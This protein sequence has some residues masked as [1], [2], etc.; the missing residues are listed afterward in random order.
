[1]TQVSLPPGERPRLIR[2]LLLKVHWIQQRGLPW[3]FRRLRNE[4]T[5]PTTAPTRAVRNLLAAL[6]GF[7]V[8]TAAALFRWL[9]SV[10]YDARR[11]L[12]FF[13]DLQVCP[14][15]YDIAT[16]MAG[17]ELER[18]RRG[19]A[20]IHVVIVPG[21]GDGLRLEVPEYDAIVSE[22]ARRWRLHN[23][24]VPV[25]GL[26]PSCGGFTI[27]ASRAH[28]ASLRLLF[29]RH[30]YPAGWQPAFPVAPEARR[31]RDAGRAGET[32][33][34][35]L[36]APP[37]ALQYVDQYLGARAARRRVLV[38]TLRQYAYTPGRN[39]NVNAWIALADGIDD[40]RYVVVF[41]LD[42]DVA[43]A[44]VP[45]EIGRHHVFQAA[46]WNVPLRMALYQ[47]AF[48][49]LA[50]VH[51]PM[52][53]CWYNEACRYLLFCPVSTAPLTDRELLEK[54]GFEIGKALPFARPWQ[55][56]I[57]EPDDLEIIRREF[58]RMVPEL[59]SLERAQ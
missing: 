24:V 36:T 41:V 54:L 6:E 42:T 10:A 40:A 27:C 4:L 48:L 56:W 49:N 37:R 15:A 13:Y 53:L 23:L 25:I 59:E 51:G 1:M 14:I 11:T 45:E 57:W 38:V 31:V 35:L 50:V 17:A 55:Q 5:T 33:F 7:A 43:M 32:V 30:V 9:P 2:R 28:A 16:F 29:A 8:S 26:M 3:V 44:P 34:P 21:R 39:S 46:S 58:T 20:R 19:L 18:R 12:Y 47:R 22:S 52:E